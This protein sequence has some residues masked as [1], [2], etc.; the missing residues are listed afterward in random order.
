[1][2]AG[3]G[4]DTVARE[5]DGLKYLTY[6]NVKNVGRLVTAA[7]PQTGSTMF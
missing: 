3:Q 4:R 1:M 5:R 2:A 7:S 6:F